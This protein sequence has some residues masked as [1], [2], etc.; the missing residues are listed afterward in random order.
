MTSRENGLG[1]QRIKRSDN[2]R[3]ENL[4]TMTDSEDNIDTKNLLS[5]E[6]P[7]ISM[8][9]RGHN[10]HVFGWSL[11]RVILLTHVNIF[12]Y[13]ACFWIQNGTLPVCCFFMTVLLG[14]ISVKIYSRSEQ[15]N[16]SAFSLI[17][18]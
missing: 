18:F 11:N 7:A 4:T 3:S 8:A 5:G 1:Y 17:N 15:V 10:I 16:R 9:N 12:L 13:S 2:N 6:K 14:R